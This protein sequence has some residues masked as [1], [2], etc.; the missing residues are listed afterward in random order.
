MVVENLQANNY[1]KCDYKLIFMDI[2]MPGVDG[3]D[4]TEKIREILYKEQL[5]QPIIVAVTGHSEDEFCEKA[6]TTGMNAVFS[7]PVKAECVDWIINEMDY[8]KEL[9]GEEEIEAVAE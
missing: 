7:K 8:P 3:Y 2:Q 1:S 5:P 6:I 9:E 4:A